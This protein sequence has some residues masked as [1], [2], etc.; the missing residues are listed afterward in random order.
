[1][2]ERLDQRCIVAAM[3]LPFLF[4]HAKRIGQAVERV[5]RQH[6]RIHQ[7]KQ[8]LAQR[9]QMAGQVAAVYSGDV[10]WW[11]RRQGFGVVPVQEVAAMARQLVQRIEGEGG[12][13]SDRAQLQ[14]AEI[15]RRQIGQQGQ[16]DVGWR[17]A[18]RHHQRRMLLD[19]VRWQPMILLA[20]PGLEEGPGTPRQPAKECPLR[21]G[22]LGHARGRWSAQPRHQRGRKGPRQQQGQGKRQCLRTHAGHHGYQHERQQRGRCHHP[23]F[24]AAVAAKAAL[25]F[26]GGVPLQQVTACDDHAPKRAQHGVTGQQRFE[27]QTRDLGGRAQQ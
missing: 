7:R 19:V 12:T 20:H 5:R 4:Q 18:P 14:I 21:N 22:K 9:Q 10:A 15:P 17:G 25:D 27:G 3:A 11:Q 26:A 1:M 23:P 8:A 13:F 24:R 16:A 2:V 6:W